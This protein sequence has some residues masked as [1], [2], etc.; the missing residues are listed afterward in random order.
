[1]TMRALRLA[2]IMIAAAVSMA[3]PVAAQVQPEAAARIAAFGPVLN[4]DLVKAMHE[5]YNPLQPKSA[6]GI[7]MT[8]DLAYGA[9]E[10]QMLDVFAPEVKPARPLPVVI[11]VHG[12]GFVAGAKRTPGTIMYQNVGL[13]YASSGMIGVVTTYR[14]APK[15]PYPAGGEDVAA[16]VRWVQA[17]IARFGGDPGRI[18][19]HGQSAGATHVGHYVFDKSLQP[20]DGRDGV[21]GAILQSAV[22]D[23]AG[24]P[25]GPNVT[26]YY[27]DPSKWDGTS[28]FDKLDGRAIPVLL[29]S[30]EL[31]PEPFKRQFTRMQEALCKR[32]GGRCPTAIEI[33]GHNHISEIFH[34]NS[35]DQSLGPALLDFIN[36]PK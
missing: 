31:N 36:S 29:L 14:L 15:H 34:L 1:M 12:G 28:Q 9:D 3:A 4:P 25:A 7:A 26:A 35:S 16:S 13:F 8:G 11:F 17:N 33:A 6:P 32:D 18:V 30:S 24:A 19:L 10:R 2:T 21:I 23:P 27:G 5:V 20:R 22:F